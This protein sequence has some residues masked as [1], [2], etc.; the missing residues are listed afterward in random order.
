[1]KILICSY[2]F[3]PSVGGIES[4]SAS[5]AGEF[6]RQGHEVR[7]VTE[8][9]G[10]GNEEH[11]FPVIRHPGARVLW[12]CYQWADVVWHNNVSMRLFWPAFFS[13]APCY[14]TTQTWL[15]GTLGEE[16]LASRLKRLTLK[17]CRNISISHAIAKH[18][19]TPSVILGNPYHSELYQVDEAI[20]RELKLIFVGRLVSDKGLMLLLKALVQLQTLQLTPSL[21]VVGSGPERT[22]CEDFVNASGLGQQV[23]FLGAMSGRPLMEIFNAHEILVIPSLWAEPFGVVALEGI[24]CGCV[25]L[26]TKDGGLQEAIG[27]CGI[28]CDNHSV[29]ALTGSLQILLTKSDLRET[30]RVQAQSHLQQFS[31]SSVASR[32]LGL[33]GQSQRTSY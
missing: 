24:A 15:S 18:L 2:A 8:T 33:F 3:S 20:P 31:A 23:R 10:A 16:T 5:L 22:A 6:S 19:Q 11:G 21:T 29:D 1:M 14:V 25:A 28:V 27:P 7:L 32:Y 30:L 12:S 26:G 13:K 9:A 17:C 4:V